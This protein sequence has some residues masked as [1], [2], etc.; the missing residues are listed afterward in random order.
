MP[1][2]DRCRIVERRLLVGALVCAVIFVISY[3]VLVATPWG[4]QFDDDAFLAR[5][6][7]TRKIVALDAGILELARKSTLLLAA[8]VT[9]IVAAIRRCAFV[10]VIALAALG[11]AVIGAEVLKHVL[12]W[13]ALAPGDASLER[14][15]QMNTFPSGHAT[16]GTSLALVFVLLSPSRWRP[17]LAVLSGC[18][19]A[20]FAAGVLFAGWHRPSDA[21]GALAWSGL[22]MSVAGALAIRLLGEP[23]T[24]LARPVAAAL[25]SASL[26]I[27]VTMATWLGSSAAA[28]EYIFADL[29][30]FVLTGSIVGGAF[31][32]SAWY[33]WQLRG[34]DWHYDHSPFGKVKRPCAV[35]P[36]G[37]HL[38]SDQSETRQVPRSDPTD[39]RP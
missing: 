36:V 13:G 21:L 26:G 34:V 7:L 1:R 8:I 2:N 23:R 32:L 4:H 10:G 39:R 17:W 18:I 9:L 19:S 3:F 30:F 37:S 12:P 29:P 15:F 25:S 20:T 31:T 38:R 6:S 11:C 27:L 35:G 22:C 16:I 33:G 24:P 28:S 14:G 5:K